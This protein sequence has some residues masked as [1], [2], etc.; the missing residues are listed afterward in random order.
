VKN[1][2]EW[3][4]TLLKTAY[5]NYNLLSFPPPSKKTEFTGKNEFFGTLRE[6]EESAKA[7]MTFTLKFKVAGN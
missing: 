1:S 4:E 7:F 2:Q 5:E 3:Q 6:V